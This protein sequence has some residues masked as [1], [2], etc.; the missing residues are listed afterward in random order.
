MKQ[1]EKKVKNQDKKQLDA[2]EKYKRLEA[3][4]EA[5]NEGHEREVKAL[6]TVV[7][8]KERAIEDI[9]SERE[10]DLKHQLDELE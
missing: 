4:F 2:S 1:F 10:Q 8:D 3:E 5:M 7:L 6:K 9:R